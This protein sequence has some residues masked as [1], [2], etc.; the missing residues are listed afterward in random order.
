MFEI[1]PIRRGTSIISIIMTHLSKHVGGHVGK[2]EHFIVPTMGNF[3]I[4]LY[5]KSEA[6]D[7][8]LYQVLM[9]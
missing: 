3:A 8:R 6:G 1:E 7:L 5:L 4:C 2:D 9:T